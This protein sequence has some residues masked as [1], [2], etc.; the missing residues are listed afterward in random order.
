MTPVFSWQGIVIA[1]AFATAMGGLLLWM[2]RLPVQVSAEAAKMRRSLY[3]ARR[4]MVPVVEA[5]YSGHAVEL[6]CRLGHE[7]KAEIVLVHVVE[8]PMTL[9]LGV[10]LPAAQEAAD[11][12]LNTA[13][14][15]VALHGLTASTHIE[16]AR[17]AGHGIVRAA[18]DQ[19][20][21]LIVMGVSPGPG[22][23]ETV[24]RTGA[25]LLRR[26]H[27]EVLLDR[28]PPSSPASA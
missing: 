25:V 4:I 23:A 16:R 22:S 20:V 28:T 26:A 24:G 1:V 13:K 2:F 11:R 6:A 21:D 19:G 12:V 8:V 15:I 3:G 14:E 17:E 9:P 7:Q 18:R 27:C 5:P 10:P